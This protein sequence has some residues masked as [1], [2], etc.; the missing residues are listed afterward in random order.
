[1]RLGLAKHLPRGYWPLIR[2]ADT[3]DACLRD[4]TL[5]LEESPISLRADLR[6]NV[7]DPFYLYGRIP[8]QFGFDQFFQ[9]CLRHGD[10]VF[11]IGTNVGYTAALFR[12][13]LARKTGFSRLSYH[14]E[15]SSSCIARSPGCGTF[16]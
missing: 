8:H 15:H 2:M 3:R 6:E 11:D 4:L 9:S 12:I 1:M 10:R 16:N 5:G 13:W 14:R 7:F